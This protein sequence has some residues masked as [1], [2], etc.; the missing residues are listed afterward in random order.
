M[1][2]LVAS[3]VLVVL[4]RRPAIIIWPAERIHVPCIWRLHHRRIAIVCKRWHG[5]LGNS[6]RVSPTQRRIQLLKGAFKVHF[7]LVCP[8]WEPSTAATTILFVHFD[9]PEKAAFRYTPMSHIFWAP[10]RAPILCYVERILRSTYWEHPPH[11]LFY[12]Q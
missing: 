9:Q 3:S 8:V 12:Y 4:M 6:A 5:N 7:L 2:C 11:G 10:S 1:S